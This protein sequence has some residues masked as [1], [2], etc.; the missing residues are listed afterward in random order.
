MAKSLFFKEKTRTKSETSFFRERPTVATGNQKSFFSK[1]GIND[2]DKSNL[3]IVLENINRAGFG[4]VNTVR[5]IIQAQKGEAEFAPG[6]AF[7]RGFKLEE[8]PFFGEVLKQDLNFDEALQ[9]IG[10]DPESK[11]NRVLTGVT[12]FVGDILFDPLTYVPAGVFTKLLKGGAKVTGVSALGRQI[13]KIPQV[14]SAGEALGKAFIPRFALRKFPTFARSARQFEDL[15]R[16]RQADIV[17]EVLGLA[18]K[19]TPQQ[20]SLM[21]QFL[22]EPDFFSRKT[23]R[24]QLSAE[25]L[26]G[27]TAKIR[28]KL[29]E[30]AKK[31]KQLGVLPNV[32]EWYFP[33]IKKDAEKVIGGIGTK[34][35]KARLPFAKARTI[36]D[37]IENVNQTF[38]KEFFEKDVFKA[39]GIRGVASSRAT[40]AQEFLNNTLANYGRR[41]KLGDNVL[42]GEGI[43][44]AKDFFR[45]SPEKFTK[46]FPFIEQPG[47]RAI[48][49][50]PTARKSITRQLQQLGKKEFKRKFPLGKKSIDDFIE[51][52]AESQ[53]VPNFDI[54][55]G[56]NRGNLDSLVRVTS[57]EAER[58]ITSVQGAQVHIL[59]QEIAEHLNTFR[60]TFTSDE[61]L[62]AFT[63]GYDRILNLWKG[64]STAANLGF[65]GRNFISNY[66]LGFLRHGP[67]IFDPVANARAAGVLISKGDPEKTWPVLGKNLGSQVINTPSG[68]I[69]YADTF[70]LM[71]QNGIINKGW[72]GSDIPNFIDRQLNFGLAENTK[73]LA[74]RLN[75]ASRHNFLLEKIGRPL[76]E[77][78]ENHAR[79]LQFIQG[80]EKGESVFESALKTRKFLFDYLD[81]TPFERNVMKR[82]IPFYS[83][84]RKNIPLQFEQ[85]LKQ[86][87]K[88]TGIIK[89][90]GEIERGIDVPDQMPEFVR[91]GFPI[92]VGEGKRNS[93]EAF[94]LRNFI[95]AIDIESVIGKTTPITE[96]Q[97]VPEIVRTAFT[98]VSPLI[99]SPI[100]QALNLDIFRGGR[101]IERFPGE[102]QRVLGIPIRKRIAKELPRPAG[103]ITRALEAFG[104]ADVPRQ[105]EIEK[106]TIP[107]AI[108]RTLFG[109]KTTAV[110][111]TRR[112]KFQAFEKKRSE[113][114]LRRELRN[115]LRRGDK[116]NA[117]RA[118]L[119]L[120]KIRTRR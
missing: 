22:D 105:E 116:P 78:V 27:R 18:K 34:P 48:P 23:L 60:K 30:F 43:Y 70:K 35:L 67:K 104:L 85:L 42:S 15:L 26:A 75:P 118:A 17:E 62:Q 82:I 65:H 108:A 54:I 10:I 84:M 14:A 1:E 36:D 57:D 73:R 33:H 44:V 46:A 107:A 99:K 90:K 120:E 71:K 113:N 3:Q 74:A 111:P 93:K 79:A 40:T 39:F 2:G 61:S 97:R 94:L 52:L 32:R 56:I 77:N 29:T 8:T 4:G 109:L 25:G 72:V 68:P 76:G 119:A 87:T 100:E 16:T 6:A 80:L 11:T 115:A 13:G 112:R 37:T 102:A 89:A 21:R 20:R 88:Y 86:P 95:P 5:N 117:R 63:K 19:T 38:S 83:W 53:K 7:A 69:T 110:S 9:S 114:R 66:W 47:K 106:P 92:F 45:R 58:M 81:V 101:P 28:E 12:G 41:A 91:S 59:P 31:E 64:Y 49:F 103:E 55:Q 51:G 98:S 24:G 50:S 96:G